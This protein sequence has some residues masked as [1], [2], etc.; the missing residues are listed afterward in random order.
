MTAAR[1]LVA[2]LAVMLGGAT[3]AAC[4]GGDAVT[5]TSARPTVVATT[6]QLGDMARAVAGGRARVEQILKANS[7][8]HAY[9]PRPSDARALADA[10]V[11][12]RSGG[13]L[14][15]WLDDVLENAGGNAR[16]VTLIDAVKTRR[17]EGGIDPHWWQDPRNAVLA[18]RAIRDALITAD[19]GGRATYS[20][21]ADAY[22]KRLRRLDRA[23]AVCIERVPEAERKLVTDHDALRYYADRYAIKVIG[24]VIPGL[25]TQAQASAAA[26]A[27]LAR[28]IRAEGVTTVF[29]AGSVNRK[30]ADAIARDSG[31]KI[32]PDLY[33]DTLGPEGSAGAT[34][35][36]SLQANTRALV[37][38]FTDGRQRC[39]L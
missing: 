32:G 9:E 15:E 28:A 31:A 17:G 14:D 33:A 5:E 26:V 10:E 18:V 20:A 21:S 1:C 8:P 19:P 25:S 38:G 11:V 4:G 36:A 16:T 3:L 12:L 23:I 13:D 6:T 34:Y 39:E 29:S 22:S 7:D 30:L 37:S 24:T 27:R 35:V 2:V